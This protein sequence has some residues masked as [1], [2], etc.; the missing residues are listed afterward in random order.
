MLSPEG[1]CKAFDISGKIS[2]FMRTPCERIKPVTT[3]SL[4]LL[5]AGDGYVRSEGVIAVLLQ[6]A[7]DAKRIY[8]NVLAAGSNCDGYKD[9]GITFPSCEMQMKLFRHVAELAG[10]DPKTIDFMEAHGSATRV[11]TCKYA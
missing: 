1:K 8:A 2:S 9:E 5:C 11:R 4:V 3:D 7:K 10:I 6:K